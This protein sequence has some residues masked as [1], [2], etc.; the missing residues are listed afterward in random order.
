MRNLL[1]AILAASLLGSCWSQISSSKPIE[2][3]AI[4]EVYL[5]DPATQTLKSLPEEHW[6]AIGKP[7]WATATGII[8]I[9][10]DRSSFRVRAGDKIAFVFNVGKP[11]VVKLYAYIQKN[12]KR[13]L[14]LVKVKSFGG[15][16]EI[17]PSI[18]AEIT[19]YGESSYRLVP[20]S[21]LSPGEYAID[22]NNGNPSMFTF[23]VDP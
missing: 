16:R 18:P 14:P 22:M 10:G 1:G 11:E 9:S 19:K 7:G 17:L 5:L 21:P 23:G 8:Q 20:K 2:P 12:D 13:Q 6:K 3:T 4:G 15:G